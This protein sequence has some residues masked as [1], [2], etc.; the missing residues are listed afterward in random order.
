MYELYVTKSSEDLRSICGSR[1]S[2]S[3]T[4]SIQKQEPAGD[5]SQP[6]PKRNMAAGVANTVV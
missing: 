2:S 3:S 4:F 1:L 5:M 6:D